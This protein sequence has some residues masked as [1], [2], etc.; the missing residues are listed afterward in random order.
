MTTQTATPAVPL[1]PISWMI[2][3]AK[4]VN[5]QPREEFVGRTKY[6]KVTK[7]TKTGICLERELIGNISVRND[8]KNKDIEQHAQYYNDLRWIY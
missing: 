8:R 7:K 1:D 3:E 6:D 2:R 4:K 5:L